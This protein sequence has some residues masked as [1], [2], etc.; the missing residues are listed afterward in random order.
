MAAEDELLAQW[1]ARADDGLRLAELALSAGPPVPWGAAFHAQQAVEELFK[2]LLTFRGIEFEKV[3]SIDYLL[4]L[5][6]SA[7]PEVDSLRAAATR[8]TDYAVES[9][10]PLPRHDP[11]EA[12][13][14]IEVARR[15][16]QFV[17]DR[18]PIDV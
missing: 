18:L 6:G 14:A 15:V 11:T 1:L 10:Y 5:L 7:E 3:H 17:R 9:R 12:R 13:E 8:L 2:A 4:D 16:G